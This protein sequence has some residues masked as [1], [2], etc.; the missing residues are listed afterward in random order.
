MR[1][2]LLVIWNSPKKKNQDLRLSV[3]EPNR[4]E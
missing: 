3:S 2:L 1:V 4:Q